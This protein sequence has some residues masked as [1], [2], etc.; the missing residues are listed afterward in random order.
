MANGQSLSSTLHRQAQ[1]PGI[2]W[3]NRSSSV[4][5]GKDE[6]VERRRLRIQGVVQ[7]VGFRPFVYGLARAHTLGGFVQN[8]GEGVVVEVE[9]EPSSLTPSY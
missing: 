6:R 5:S 3:Q 1:D 2:G 9:G 8:T 7:G 4:T